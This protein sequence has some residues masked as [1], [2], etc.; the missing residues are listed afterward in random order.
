LDQYRCQYYIMMPF[1]MSFSVFDITIFTFLTRPFD[2]LQGIAV[3]L[4]YAAIDQARMWP[5]TETTWSTWSKR[6]PSDA[7]NAN[8]S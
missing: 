3:E 7:S 5:D 6:T 4:P 8:T 1:L 2:P